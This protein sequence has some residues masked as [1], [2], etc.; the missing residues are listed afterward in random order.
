MTGRRVRRLVAF[1]AVLTVG[2]AAAAEHPAIVVLGKQPEAGAPASSRAYANAFRSVGY[3]VSWAAPAEWEDAPG[4]VVVVPGGEAAALDDLTRGRILGFVE[5]GGRLV[6]ACDTPLARSLGVAFDR[7]AIPVAGA[8]DVTAREVAIRWGAPVDV[9]R[10]DPPRHSAVHTWAQG[11]NVPLVFSFRHGLGAVLFLAVELDESNPLGS[12]R[13]P[14]FLHA[15]GSAFG[16]SPALA[17][18]HIVAYADL[19]DHARDD[20]ERMA[21]DWR[22]RGIPEIHLNAWDAVGAKLA[23]YDRVIAACHRRGIVVYA[24]FELP[25]VSRAFWDAHPQWREKTAHGRDGHVD[26]RRL[27]ALTMPECFAAVEREVTGL[28][29]RFDWDGADLAEVYFESPMGLDRPDVLTPMNA[30]VREEFKARTGFDPKEIFEKNSPRYFAKDPA[31]L[32]LF[33]E[34]RREKVVELHEKLLGVLGGVRAHTPELDI[35]VTL[36]DALYD[37]NM[38]DFMAV[39]TQRIVALASRFPF[40]LEV[41]DAYTL[42][43]LGPERYTR[44]AA[45]YARLVAPG[46]R[47]AVDINVVPRAEDQLPTVQQTGVELYTLAAVARRAFPKVCFYSEDSIFRQDRE[48]LPY[49]MASASRYRP[50]GERAA[51]VEGDGDAELA[52]GLD[53][54]SVR[55]DGREWPAVRGGTVLLPRGRHALEWTNAAAPASGLRLVGLTGIL[56]DASADSGALT[57]K[58]SWPARGFVLL[59]RPPSGV[60]LDGTPLPFTVGKSEAGSALRVPPGEHTL[61]LLP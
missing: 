8:T 61:R 21:D 44:I 3:P 20:P 32:A 56:L 51:A 35:V 60:E 42:W 18:P 4:T 16:A 1:A 10:P 2:S 59:S 40:E 17:S 48:L 34:Y 57:V 23:F 47:L 36:M 11:R 41:E 53:A 58:V 28:L 29:Q 54:A 13:F 15:F 22:H 50:T 30:F 14:Y 55:L 37:T 43:G 45:D 38:R 27:M 46:Q 25:L 6:T 49:A 7:V 5:S 19:G 9:H 39:D 52:T 33:Y 26:W 24:W 31:P 12:S